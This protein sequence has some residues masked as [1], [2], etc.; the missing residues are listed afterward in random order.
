MLRV[1]RPQRRVRDTAGAVGTTARARAPRRQ[2]P[3]AARTAG[4]R[5]PGRGRRAHR[6]RVRQQPPEIFVTGAGEGTQV[7]EHLKRPSPPPRG[8]LLIGG[9]QKSK[10]NVCNDRKC[11]FFLV[12][13]S[14]GLRLRRGL[15]QPRT[16][17]CHP[18]YTKSSFAPP[19]HSLVRY[20]DKS[21]RYRA[22]TRPIPSYR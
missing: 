9:R 16:Q 12:H 22:S 21:F 13:S 20:L 15:C 1:G 11:V 8:K 19:S 6:R 18:T 3:R 7:L 17:N 10:N 14:N 2:S 4:A 5:P